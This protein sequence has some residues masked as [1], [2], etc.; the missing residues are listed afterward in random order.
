MCTETPS[1]HQDDTRASPHTTVLQHCKYMNITDFVA[2]IYILAKKNIIQLG[3]LQRDDSSS[4]SY[5]T[6]NKQV[7]SLIYLFRLKLVFW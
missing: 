4:Y 7:I 1:F 3:W 5:V 2:E 6:V